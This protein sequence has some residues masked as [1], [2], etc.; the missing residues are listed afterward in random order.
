MRSSSSDQEIFASYLSF[1]NLL[2]VISDFAAICYILGLT[3]NHLAYYSIRDLLKNSPKRVSG[4]SSWDLPPQVGYFEQSLIFLK[5][6]ITQ[7][8]LLLP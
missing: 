5:C 7:E 4:V 2:L 6:L 3:G 8:I 1:V